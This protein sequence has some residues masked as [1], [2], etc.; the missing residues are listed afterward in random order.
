MGKSVSSEQVALATNLVQ[1]RL[2]KALP[3]SPWKKRHPPP[4]KEARFTCLEDPLSP[5]WTLVR[6]GGAV[7]FRGSD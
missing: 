3:T 1:D 5:P 6:A 2:A 4:G 7:T